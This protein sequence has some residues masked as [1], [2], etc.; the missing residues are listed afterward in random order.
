MQ[1]VEFIDKCAADEGA[2]ESRR[3]FPD[4]SKDTGRSCE[5]NL[6]SCPDPRVVVK[7]DRLARRS[8]RVRSGLSTR[9]DCEHRMSPNGHRRCDFVVVSGGSPDVRVLFIEVKTGGKEDKDIETGFEQLL[10]SRNVFETVMEGLQP[11]PPQPQAAA[12]VVVS[13]GTSLSDANQRLRD[14]L[15]IKYRL[16]LLQARSGDDLW[17][18]A[19]VP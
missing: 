11:M 9:C 15:T 3:R 8:A 4:H 12:G 6:E 1:L 13:L 2:I 16:P 18:K 19:F 17:L 10:C 5:I 7:V 14:R